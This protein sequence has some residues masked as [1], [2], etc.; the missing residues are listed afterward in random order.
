ML[1]ITRFEQ[2]ID[3]SCDTAALRWFAWRFPALDLRSFLACREPPYVTQHHIV[4]MEGNAHAF[5]NIGILARRMLPGPIR[6]R[7]RTHQIEVQRLTPLRIRVTLLIWADAPLGDS[8][9][10][11]T[12]CPSRWPIADEPC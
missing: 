11:A 2:G 5:V 10:L 4:E 7:R 1:T 3:H 12:L 8:H 9:P 6:R